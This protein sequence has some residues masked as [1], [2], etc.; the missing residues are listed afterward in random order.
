MDSRPGDTTTGPS[1][2]PAVRRR[3]RIPHLLLALLRQWFGRPK[4][5]G[6]LT[7]LHWSRSQSS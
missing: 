6:V 2:R 7:H 5:I 3:P 4:R 1:G